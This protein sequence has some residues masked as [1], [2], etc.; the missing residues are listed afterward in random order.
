MIGCILALA[1]LDL[2]CAPEA[3]LAVSVM[4]IDD[5]VL[6]EN[7]GTAD[8]IAIVTSPW[9]EQQFELAIGESV[10]VTGITE[11]IEVSAVS[12]TTS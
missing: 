3:T 7:T 10:T 11:P 5:G 12:S 8:R 4:E 1:L 2:S 6:I 9:G